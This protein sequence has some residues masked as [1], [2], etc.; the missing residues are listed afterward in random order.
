MLGSGLLLPALR[1]FAQDISSFNTLE[2]ASPATIDKIR[3]CEAK[4]AFRRFILQKYGGL[5]WPMISFTV[6]NESPITIRRIYMNAVLRMGDRRVPLA[7]H[8]LDCSIPNGLQPGETRRFA[9]D[10]DVVGGWS[11]VTKE[12]ARRAAFSLTLM[13]VEDAEG[14]KIVR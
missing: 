9:L 5:E 7:D 1:A 3:I 11:E 4:F 12:E 8:R 14:G 6:V 13:A 10:A 2:T